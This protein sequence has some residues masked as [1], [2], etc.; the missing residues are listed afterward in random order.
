MSDHN[1]PFH[2]ECRAYGRL[3]EVGREDLAVRAYGYISLPLTKDILKSMHR[4]MEGHRAWE[5]RDFMDGRVWTRDPRDILGD[6]NGPDDGSWCVMGILKDWLG[7]EDIGKRTLYEEGLDQLRQPPMFRRM[8]A[9]LKALHRCGVIHCDVKLDQWV[10]GMLVD[11]SSAMTIPHMHGPGG[12]AERPSWTFA[13][14]ATWDLVCFQTKV[15]DSWNNT[16]W[17]EFPGVTPPRRKCRFRA[18]ELPEKL[19]VRQQWEWQRVWE[20]R[21]RL[22]RRQPHLPPLSEDALQTRSPE[23]PRRIRDSLRPRPR[24]H[25]PFL[26]LINNEY[27]ETID[28]VDLS[29]YDPAEFNWRAAGARVGERRGKKMDREAEVEDIMA[30]R[31]RKKLERRRA[32]SKRKKGL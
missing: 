32:G 28:L 24:Q 5:D 27:S 9:D 17:S 14:V 30:E 23:P 25:G 10:D 4:A 19:K 31:R 22:R 18:Y 3:K 13:S 15:V 6:P 26:P 7:R 8:L 21:R 2:C 11:L 16:D 20:A 1:D 12:I 29:P